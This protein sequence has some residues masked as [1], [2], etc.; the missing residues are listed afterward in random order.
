[1]VVFLAA[2][3][4]ERVVMVTLPEDEMERVKGGTYEVLFNQGV[5]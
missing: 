5:K 3:N 2:E 4:E 1:M